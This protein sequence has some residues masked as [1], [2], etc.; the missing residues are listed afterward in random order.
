[1]NQ[2]DSNEFKILS[3]YTCTQNIDR[4]KY[5]NDSLTPEINA[6]SVGY[7]LNKEKQTKTGGIF[8]F[9]INEQNGSLEPI[10]KHTFLLDYG[11]LD[12]KFNT[13]NNKQLLYTSNSDNSYSIFDFSSHSSNK[14]YIESSP[15]ITTCN[16]LDIINNTKIILCSND[17]YYHIYDYTSNEKISSVKSH[18]FGIWSLYINDGNTFFTGSE[19]NSIKLWD[20]RSNNKPISV[21]NKS[22]DS[23]INSIIKLDID[24]NIILT[25]SYD[26]KVTFFDLRK[27]PTELKQIK[28]EH[29][30]WD[31]K[32]TK[33]HKGDNL[34]LMASIYEGFN[35]WSIDSSLN[36]IHKLR[37]PLTKEE[38]KYHRSIVYGIDIKQRKDS[39]EILSCSFYDN[40]I[41]HWN[42]HG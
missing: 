23:S 13:N 16:T 25:G 11:I 10:D 19:D 31:I 33:S 20:I 28:T 30:T 29:S 24:S 8:P 21:N 36:M 37:L 38:D 2:T 41:M 22:F 5:Y 17:G 15:S 14:Y 3:K 40:L 32:Q 35:I 1:M 34:L 7:H 9:A 12:I 39:V 27:F 4:I 18:E 42:Y 26:E 6:L